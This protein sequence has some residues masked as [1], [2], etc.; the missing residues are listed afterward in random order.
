M[1]FPCWRTSRRW[2]WGYPCQSAKSSLA[3]IL[4]R[5]LRPNS[6]LPDTKNT[7]ATS[8][9]PAYEYD[10]LSS[11]AMMIKREMSDGVFGLLVDVRRGRC[12][13]LSWPRLPVCHE[14]IS[15][16]CTSPNSY[17][18]FWYTPPKLAFVTRVI[19]HLNFV[20]SKLGT[21]YI[22]L[23]RYMVRVMNMHHYILL[24][25]PLIIYFRVCLTFYSYFK[26][27]YIHMILIP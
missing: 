7:R 12:S 14:Q 20:I 4:P 18:I 3:W 17:F 26:T 24:K 25:G 23:F 1:K 21:L 5:I 6:I 11:M 16:H 13:W 27:R 8:M 15:K 2:N 22:T 10:T 19:Y 9:G